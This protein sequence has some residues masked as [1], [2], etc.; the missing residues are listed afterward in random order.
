[1]LFLPSLRSLTL[2]L[3]VTALV[4]VLASPAR[5]ADDRPCAAP[6]SHASFG[7]VQYCPLWM[8]SRGS[9]PVHRLDGG[10]TAEVGRLNTAGSVNWFV[11][12]SDR[13]G[14]RVIRY[15]DPGHAAYTNVWWART[16]SDTGAWGWTSEVYF[17][18]GG[19]DERDARLRMC[20][21]AEAA[22]AGVTPPGG[23]APAPVAPA[24]APRK[25]PLV[26]DDD[27]SCTGPPR[28]M[29]GVQVRYR[30]HDRYVFETNQMSMGRPVT[31]DVWQ[32]AGWIGT[33]YVRAA[34]CPTSQGW[35]ILPGALV[36]S[37]SAGL[38]GRG[39]PRGKEPERKWGVTMTSA[40]G[41]TLSVAVARCYAT[42]SRW[43]IFKLLSQV[44]LPARF[45]ISV[46]LWGVGFAIPDEPQRHCRMLGASP[47]RLGVDA[48][49]RITARARGIGP[50]ILRTDR[51]H[52]SQY[53]VVPYVTLGRNLKAP[54]G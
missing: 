18:G 6:T 50:V 12:Q 13:V 24:P 36:A 49:G 10:V 3:L 32:R 52:Y 46:A 53:E 20:T 30:L 21:A 17:S 2:C 39:E 43:R 11:C 9:V 47:L 35:R 33:S 38:D 5:A 45:T 54:A 26:L 29:Q 37:G 42:A 23:V 34:S 4:T 51:T 7:P 19:N 40:E 15:R 14:G 44:P 27:R 8:P 22:V 48:R 41:G 28:T 25:L 1:M 31:H 16:L